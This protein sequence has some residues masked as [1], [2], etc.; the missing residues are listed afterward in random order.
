MRNVNLDV[1]CRPMTTVVAALLE[2]DGLVLACRRRE[3]D[4]HPLKWEFPGGKVEAGE[5]PTDA[6]RRELQEELGIAAEIGEEVTRYEYC[7]PDKRPILLI[8][9]RVTNFAGEPRNRV[10][11]EI[12]WA[13]AIQLRDLDFLEGDVDFV[14]TLA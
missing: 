9:Y 8:F 3:H 7:Y 11:Q 14:R 2:R 10:F 6:L 4:P 13:P 5:S 1:K 12:Q